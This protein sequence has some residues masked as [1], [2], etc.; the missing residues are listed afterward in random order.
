MPEITFSPEGIVKIIES[1]KITSSAGPDGINSKVL[2]NT[3]CI[4]SVILS[5][6]FQQS[7]SCSTLPHE[8]KLGK[9]VPVPKKGP[10][11]YRPISLTSVCSKIMEHVIY[12]HTVNFLN[13]VNFFNPS[14]HVFQKLFSCET[15]LALFL[16]DIHVSLDENVDAL[17]I[18]FEKAFDKV[19]HK[20]L[21]L[22]LSRLDLHP[23]VYD[24]TSS[25]TDSNFCMQIIH[26]RLHLLSYTECHKAL[27]WVHS[28]SSFTS[29][30][31]LVIFL[32]KYACSPTTVS[33]IAR[34]LASPIT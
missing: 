18:D 33:F 6:I 17:F 14:Q 27:Y 32:Q 21:L 23:L 19:P 34:S 5:H 22:K 1:L 20:R 3:K 29:T 10:S 26:R 4:T 13:S 30:T 2:K 9:I 31:C 16:H 7:L 8:W 15:Q 12:T 28:F 25:L 24:W 11:S